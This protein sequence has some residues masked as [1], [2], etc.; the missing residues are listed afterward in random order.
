MA[1][2]PADARHEPHSHRWAIERALRAEQARSERYAATWRR[3]RRNTRDRARRARAREVSARP[4][5]GR[6]NGVASS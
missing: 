4:D 3:L 1:D 5:T 6:T 2:T